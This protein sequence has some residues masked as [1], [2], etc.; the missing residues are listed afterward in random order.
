MIRLQAINPLCSSKRTLV[1]IAICF[2]GTALYFGTWKSKKIITSDVV[3]YYEYLT[4]GLMFNDLS[5]DF[6]FNLPEDFDGEIWL[7]STEKGNRAVKMTMGTA[8]MMTPFYCIAAAINYISGAGSYGYS[9]LFQFFILLGSLIYCMLGLVFQ[10]KLLKRYFKDKT[11]S[12]VLII[13]ALGTNLTSYTCAEAGMSHVYSFFLFS[14]FLYLT[15]TW[16]ESP[17]WAN[18]ILLGLVLGLITLVRPPNGL[19]VLI[20]A[21]YGCFSRD[22]LQEKWQLVRQNIHLVLIAVLVSLAVVSLQSMFWYQL[23]G[24]WLVYGYGEE[25][26]FWN[27][28]KFIDVLI[29]FRKGFITYSPLVVLGVVGIFFK[30]KN[31]SKIKGASLLF[32]AINLYV[33]SSWWCWWY[34]G[35][36]GMRALVESLAVISIFM[37]VFVEFLTEKIKNKGRVIAGTLVALFIG[38]NYVQMIQYQRGILHYDGMT[39]KAYKNI[40]LKFQ[41]PPNYSEYISSPDYKEA[42]KGNR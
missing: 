14:W 8:V 30:Q 13:L 27:D 32:L 39:A 19:L 5:F 16:H 40:F 42:V 37:A 3:I 18:S 1:F 20:P 28:P 17:K 29:G 26:F 41:Y 34:G 10:R 31:I 2:L 22:Q 6:A 35:G 24:K 33:V 15:V 36:Y 11:V 9:S 25:G 23:S 21:F 7:E 12:V 4:A 38:L